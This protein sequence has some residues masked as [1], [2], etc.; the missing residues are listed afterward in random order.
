MEKEG[1]FTKCKEEF[2]IPNFEVELSSFR[3]PRIS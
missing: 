2:Y 3:N 1:E